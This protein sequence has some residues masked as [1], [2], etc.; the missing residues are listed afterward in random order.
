MKHFKNRKDAY[1]EHH[2]Y[3]KVKEIINKYFKTVSFF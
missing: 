3:K 2:D 1:E